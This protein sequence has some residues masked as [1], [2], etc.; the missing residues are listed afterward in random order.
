[1]I[2]SLMLIFGLICL[3]TAIVHLA[4]ANWE[5]THSKIVLIPQR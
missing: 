4:R 3:T 2:R 1:M 5:E